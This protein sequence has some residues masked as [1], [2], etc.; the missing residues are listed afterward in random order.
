MPIV[1]KN[2]KTNRA[3]VLEDFMTAASDAVAKSPSIWKAASQY[4]INRHTK[5]DSLTERPQQLKHVYGYGAPSDELKIFINWNWFGKTCEETI[6]NV[7]TKKG[8]E[9]IVPLKPTKVTLLS[10][11]LYYSENSIHDL[12]PFCRP[13]LSQQCCDVYFIY[14]TVAT[15]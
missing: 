5:N 3:S 6:K 10:M 9:A 12:R 7:L 8:G 1:K 13:F 15:Q 2:K 11:I 4:E 14:H